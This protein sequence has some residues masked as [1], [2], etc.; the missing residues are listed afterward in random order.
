MSVKSVEDEDW[1]DWREDCW[2]KSV[3]Y[4]FDVVVITGW[5]Y[6]IWYEDENVL[7]KFVFGIKSTI[8]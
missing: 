7:L 2:I 1:F 3:R 4:E 6:I 8:P 5:D